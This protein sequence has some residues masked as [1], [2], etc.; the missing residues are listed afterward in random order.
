MTDL[1]PLAKQVV[2][3]DLLREDYTRGWDCCLLRWTPSQMAGIM[4]SDPDRAA[5][6]KGGFDAA[7]LLLN[8]VAGSFEKWAGQT[9]PPTSLPNRGEQ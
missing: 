2:T 5:A 8:Q 9:F 6:L 7:Q 1:P 4:P 3:R